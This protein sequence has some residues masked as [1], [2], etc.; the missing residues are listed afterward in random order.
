MG[1]EKYSRYYSGRISKAKGERGG[2]E[3]G[4]QEEPGCEARAVIAYRSMEELGISGAEIARNLDMN[5]SSIYRASSIMDRCE[6]NKLCTV[7]INI[8]KITILG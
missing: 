5:T 6:P 7:R 2:A 1:R 4:E 8:P 3:E